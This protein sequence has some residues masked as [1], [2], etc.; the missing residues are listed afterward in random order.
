MSLIGRFVR[1]PYSIGLRWEY[2]SGF[3]FTRVEGFYNELDLFFSDNRHLTTA[4]ETQ[5][6]YDEPFQGTLPP[7]HRLDI[8]LERRFRAKH[9]DGAIQAGIMNVY[10]RQNVFYYDLFAARRVDQ[11]PFLPTIGLRI[12]FD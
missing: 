7:Y 9:V 2:G 6:L 5:I 11:L 1:G 3:P 8:T 10:D 4:G 12:E